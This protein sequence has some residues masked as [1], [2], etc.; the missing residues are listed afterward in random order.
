MTHKNFTLPKLNNPQRDRYTQSAMAMLQAQQH[1]N[2]QY[3]GILH[4]LQADAEK[5]ISM[6]HYPKGDRIDY[7]TGSQY[8]YHC[9][10]EDEATDE[11][12]HFHTFMRKS[13]IA[14]RRKRYTCPDGTVYEHG[15]MTHLAA[16]SLNRHGQLCRIFTV[17]RWVTK[18]LLYGHEDLAHFLKKYRV[19]QIEHAPEFKPLDQWLSAAL[20]LF[21]PQIV[22][23]QQQRDQQY[24]LL[25]KGYKGENLYIDRDIEELSSLPVSL[26]EQVAW[27]QQ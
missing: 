21:T 17:N 16:V 11:H 4:L 25:S 14:K 12:G 10:R 9:H 27:L 20:H 18:E 24:K 15:P 3:G 13:H 7:E 8:F 23:L 19:E 1:I 26:E 5:F 22:W 2:E 6:H